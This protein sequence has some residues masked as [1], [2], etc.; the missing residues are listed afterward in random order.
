MIASTKRI[1]KI[2]ILV[3]PLMSLAVTPWTNFDPINL[4]KLCVLSSAAFYILGILLSLSWKFDRFQKILLGVIV[5][6]LISMTV[7]FFT[8]GAPTNQQFWGVFGRNTGYLTYFCLLIIL[9]STV[10]VSNTIFYRNIL[11]TLIITAI[12]VTIYCLI[13]IAKLDP[14]TWSSKQ[15]FATFGNTNF[16]SAFLGMSSI[17]TFTMTLNKDFSSRKKIIFLCFALLQV[18]VVK[19]ADSIQGIL[20]F[21]IGI[22]VFFGNYIFTNYKNCRFPYLLASLLMGFGFLFGLG[23][24]GPLANLLYQ[25]S[26]LLR[27]DYWHAGFVMTLKHPVVGVGLDSYGDW[28][29]EY[30]GS[31]STM[32]T[33]PERTANVAHNIFLDL[34]STGGFPLLF[35]YLSIILIGFYVSI[36]F[37]KNQ[38]NFDV[39]FAG[40]FSCWIAYL[41]QALISI[42]QIAVGIWGW[43]LTGA[44]IGYALS[45]NVNLH[46]KKLKKN[47]ANLSVKTSL[48]SLIFLVIGVLVSIFPLKTD[49]DYR[50]A[51]NHGD[52]N[53]LMTSSTQ[54]GSTAF[55]LSNVISLAIENNYLDQA[56]TLNNILVSKYPRELYG[57]R[58]IANLSKYSDSEKKSARIKI[59]DLDPFNPNNPR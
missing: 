1:Q 49:A 50:S 46:E 54:A 3:G 58:I 34:S 35:A 18:G 22:V 9:F 44:T 40:I 59:S 10:V 42:N 28:Y 43:L 12:P 5:F 20:M 53:K 38:K 13:Q 39:V 23:N 2:L 48:M 55:H 24:K 17:A 25:P 37:L 31:I 14:I 36:K 41:A 56:K 33:D 6:F 15:V 57:W 30:R 16:L 4:V 21:G 27:L 45:S 51:R 32:R 8:S 26:L 47:F 29:R 7:T 11:K 52:L 19:F